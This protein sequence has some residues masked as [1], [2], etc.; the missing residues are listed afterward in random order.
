[1][2]DAKLHA[3]YTIAA[4]AL[5]I[6]PEPVIAKSKDHSSVRARAIVWWVFHHLEQV[7]CAAIASAAGFS[8]SNIRHTANAV[9]NAISIHEERSK[10]RAI[11]AISAHLRDQETTHTCPHCGGSRP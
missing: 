10:D 4:E 3:A 9:C 6:R 8:P 7:S 5:N 2:T 1:M 11:A